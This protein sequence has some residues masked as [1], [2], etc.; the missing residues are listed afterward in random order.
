MAGFEFDRVAC[1][2]P[3]VAVV[4]LRGEIDLTNARELAER[5]EEYPATGMLVLDLNG[6]SFVDSAALHCL[7][8]IARERG[9]PSGLTLAVDPAAPICA[10]FRIVQLERAAPIVP[11]VTDALTRNRNR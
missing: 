11:T 1:D 10:T 7:F 2:D 6:V 3:D 9:G 5:L 8:R 4:V